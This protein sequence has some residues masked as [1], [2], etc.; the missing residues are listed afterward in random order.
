VGT[1]LTSQ[2]LLSHPPWA[3]KSIVAVV[4]LEVSGKVYRRAKDVPKIEAEQGFAGGVTNV[5]NLVRS[6]LLL[7]HI[8]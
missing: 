3:E 6:R 2:T 5:H 7:L 1:E 8:V 4:L